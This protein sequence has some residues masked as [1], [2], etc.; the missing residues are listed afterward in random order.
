MSKEIA[1]KDSI[2]LDSNDISDFCSGIDPQ[3]EDSIED[4][5]GFNATGVDESIPGKR[6]QTIVLTVFDSSEMH[7]IFWPIYKNRDVVPF[8]WRPDQSLPVGAD[9]QSLEGNVQ[10]SN[11]PR[12]RTRGSVA[13]FQVTLITGD[14]D[15]LDYVST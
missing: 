13:T 11:Y 5:S 15:G 3:M 6:T 9:N 12:S 1:L 2:S 8:A 4:V 10:I 7:A 14:A